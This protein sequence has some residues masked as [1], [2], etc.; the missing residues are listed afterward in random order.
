MLILSCIVQET[1]HNLI[2]PLLVIL[3]RLRAMPLAFRV[4]NAWNS[5]KCHIQRL[6]PE[7]IADIFLHAHERGYLRDGPLTLLSVCREWRE[8]ALQSY[9]LWTDLHLTTNTRVN[10]LRM[11][12]IYVCH[13]RNF[14]LSVTFPSLAKLMPQFSKIVSPYLGNQIEL[15]RLQSLYLKG[16]TAIDILES[17]S[18][19]YPQLKELSLV[20]ICHGFPVNMLRGCQHLDYLTLIFTVETIDVAFLEKQLLNFYISCSEYKIQWNGS[21][22]Y[23]DIYSF[24]LKIHSATVL[25]YEHLPGTAFLD[26]EQFGLIPFELLSMNPNLIV[27]TFKGLDLSEVNWDVPGRLR[28]MDSLRVLERLT[29]SGSLGCPSFFHNILNAED[30]VY[31]PKLRCLILTDSQVSHEA[32]TRFINQR[33]TVTD[34]LSGNQVFKTLVLENISLS[35]EELSSLAGICQDCNISLR[36]WE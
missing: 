34:D 33:K 2:T 16:Q 28:T 30:F 32:L 8:I 3:G 17:F 11:P 13:S 26:D 18:F 35:D 7:I 20:D 24:L 19:S 14:K 9:V 29:I 5:G 10:P 23:N 36:I 4:Y 27:L 15:P 12:L 21:Y 25:A 22:L 6:P 31:F 1:A